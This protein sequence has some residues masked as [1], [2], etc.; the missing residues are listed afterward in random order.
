MSDIANVLKAEINRLARKELRVQLE[1]YKKAAAQT[2]SQLAALREEVGALKSQ[3]KAMGKQARQVA[4]ISTQDPAEASRK[5][6]TSKGFATMRARLGL[7]CEQMGTLVGA[8][9]QSVRKW[10]DGTAVP[11]EKSQQ[12]IFALRG[13][14]KKEIAARLSSTEP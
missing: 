6:F 3:I 8:S 2:R 14:G 5:R 1:P 4:K 12:A 7:S 10:E 13:L 11:R 9:G